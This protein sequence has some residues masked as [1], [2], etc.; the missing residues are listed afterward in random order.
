[1][2]AA[3]GF[4]VIELL[5]A[6]VVLALLGA[7]VAPAWHE[8]VVRTRRHEA[9]ATMERLM[10][11]QERYYTQNGSYLA[12]S[13]R[14]TDPEQRQFQ[15]WSG[16]SAQTSSHEIE[17]RAC[18]GQRL[19]ECLQLLATPGTAM[20]DAGFRDRGCEQLILTSTGLRL[21]RGPQSQCWR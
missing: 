20:V 15:W 9:Q 4:T 1:M 14:S 13:A 5:I 12:F 19:S 16:A 21:A 10:L 18:D 3:R 11:Q 6:L 8:Q 7:A 2:S 17:G